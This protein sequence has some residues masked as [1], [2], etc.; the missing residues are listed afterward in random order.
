MF[1][2]GLGFLTVYDLL[3]N[4]SKQSEPKYTYADFVT[5]DQG[6]RIPCETVL[7]HKADHGHG[8]RLDY[9]IRFGFKDSTD[10]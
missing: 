2:G 3:V 5:D 10:E 4:S 6:K 1:E 7:T 8:M 9:M